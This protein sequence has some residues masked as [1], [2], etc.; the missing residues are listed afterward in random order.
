M[1]AKHPLRWAVSLSVAFGL[2]VMCGMV[3]LFT[4]TYGVPVP[5]S[6]SLLVYWGVRTDGDDLKFSFGSTCDPPF[7]VN[8][9]FASYGQFAGQDFS[10]STSES[11]AGFD[12]D[13][14][15]SDAVILSSLPESYDWRKS[16]MMTLYLQFSDTSWSWLY[17]MAE[18]D[19]AEVMASDQ[20][21]S[22]EYY[23]GDIGWMTPA[24][25]AAR[26]GVDLLTVCHPASR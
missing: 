3:W 10:F 9:L 16:P 24:E 22:N 17:G 12:M 26:D 4:H 1:A 23:F 25:V 20:H 5:S 21:P 11:I 14:L 15:P 18:D 2:L 6:P 19:L 8:V 7:T 13:A